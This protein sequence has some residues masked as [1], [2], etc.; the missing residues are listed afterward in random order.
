MSVAFRFRAFFASPAAPVAPVAPV[1]GLP[2]LCLGA[3]VAASLGLGGCE[4]TQPATPPATPSA[5]ASADAPAAAGQVD[6]AVDVLSR[7]VP[8]LRGTAAANGA[9]ALYALMLVDQP[10]VL[11]E[12]V[13]GTL[14]PD[15]EREAVIFLGMGE[16]KSEGYGVRITGVEQRGNELTV[17]AT[18]DRPQ[19]E[20]TGD[21]TTPWSAVVV[22]R[23]DGVSGP[24]LSDFR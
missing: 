4:A 8:I 14:K 15:F 13:V 21:A 10:G 3:V 12:G 22:P 9:P 23:V 7:T 6:E 24:L 2:A 16:Q 1:G 20:A 17:A 11:P 19:G 5:T 18:F